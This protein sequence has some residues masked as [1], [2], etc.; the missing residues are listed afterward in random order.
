VSPPF[1]WVFHSP[2]A[3]LLIPVLDNAPFT[4]RKLIISRQDV[5]DAERFKVSS[6]LGMLCVLAD[7]RHQASAFWIAALFIKESTT[8]VKEIQR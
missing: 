8:R 6:P 4:K 7:G 2:D 3:K 1:Y 5:T